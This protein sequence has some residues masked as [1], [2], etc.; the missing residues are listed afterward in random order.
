VRMHLWSI[1]WC[2]KD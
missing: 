1:S 2:W